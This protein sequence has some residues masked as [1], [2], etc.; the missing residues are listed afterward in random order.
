MNPQLNRPSLSQFLLD[1]AVVKVGYGPKTEGDGVSELG[2]SNRDNRLKDMLFAETIGAQHFNIVGADLCGLF[3]EFGTEVQQR[4]VGK[5]NFCMSMVNGDLF[6]IGPFKAKHTDDF[7]MSGYTI[8]AEVCRGTCQK[9]VFFLPACQRA[10]LKQDCSNQVDLCIDK[11]GP[12]RLGWEEIGQKSKLFPDSSKRREIPVV[13]G[14][15]SQV[16]HRLT[17]SDWAL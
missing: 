11:I 12:Q 3:V 1:S 15:V 14:L 6:R 4:F 16:G 9:D 10:I 5:G 17:P 2:K 13:V 7:A 8:G